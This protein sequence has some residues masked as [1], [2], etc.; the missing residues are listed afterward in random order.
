V[1]TGINILIIGVLLIII[2]QDLKYRLIHACL[3]FFLFIAGLVRYFILELPYEELLFTTVYLILVILGL[4]IYTS[5]KFKKIYNP[6][7]SA[8]GLGDIAFFIAII[9]LF[10]ST[11]FIFFFIT[12][13]FF[14]ILSYL[15]LNKNKESNVPL[16]GYLAIYLLGWIAID[17]VA[18]RDFFY[19]HNII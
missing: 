1:L 6:I 11:T 8:I 2:Y 13:M 17:F 12:G 10:F 5:I 7:D 18:E 14:S 3:P 16:A 15:I 4:F 19:T 9:P